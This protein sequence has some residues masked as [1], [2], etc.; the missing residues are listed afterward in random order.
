MATI[1]HRH[2]GLQVAL[3]G[4]QLAAGRKAG[5]ATN[6]R[7]RPADQGSGVHTFDPYQIP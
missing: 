3:P 6:V 4:E 1:A 7:L 2:D 5:G